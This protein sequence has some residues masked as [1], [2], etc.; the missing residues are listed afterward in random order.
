M[1]NKTRANRNRGGAQTQFSM[2]PRADIPRSKF[3]RSHALKTAFNSGLLVPIFVDEALPGDTFN[4][5]TKAFLRLATPVFPVMDNIYVDFFFFAVP[6]RLVWDNF[7]KMH[8]EQV[9]PGDS[10]DFLIPQIENETVAE[11]SLSNYLGLPIAGAPIDFSALWHRSYNLI[12]NEWFRSED[13]QDSLTVP[14]DDG[15]DLSATYTLQRRGKRHDYF[16]SAL[17]FPQKGDAVTLPLGDSAPIVSDG[18]A[19]NVNSPGGPNNNPLWGIAAQTVVGTQNAHTGTGTFTWGN[20]TG[21]E[22]DLSSATA[23]TINQ[24]REA[25]QVQR[26]L[27]RDARGGTRYTEVIRSHFGVVSPDQRLQRPEYLGGGSTVIQSHPVAQHLSAAAP[28]GTLGAFANG[29][30]EGVGFTKSFTEHCLLLG[31]VSARADLTY[32][33]GIPRM[34]SRR[35]RFDHFYPALA[36]L[37]EQAILSKELYADGSANDDDVFGYQERYAEYRYKQSWT[38]G[39]M[40]SG[41]ATPLDQ[42]HLGLDFS[43]RPLLNDVFIEENPPIARVVAVAADEFLGDFWFQLTTARPMP[44]RSVPGLVDHF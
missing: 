4:L 21:L 35:T 18:T 17:P 8:G 2:I 9:D 43:S 25:F 12:W 36:H 31:L 24:I 42:W 16:T 37:G 33:Q 1:R 20:N 13:L 34:F 30:V 32:Q 28:L 27:E 14:K 29:F 19:P 22:A 15:P 26:L 41:Y 10:T 3:D 23:A 6:Y 39:A 7:Q 38:S 5:R 11:D 40:N 44:V